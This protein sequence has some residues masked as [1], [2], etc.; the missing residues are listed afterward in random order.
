LKS[1]AGGLFYQDGEAY[2]IVRRNSLE[3][4]YQEMTG[5]KITFTLVRITEKRAEGE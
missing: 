2:K 3:F 4:V 1:K 5:D